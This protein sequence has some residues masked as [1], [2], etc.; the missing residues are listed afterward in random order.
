M[1]APLGAL[2]PSQTHVEHADPIP[3]VPNYFTRELEC[4]WVSISVHHSYRH[5]PPHSMQR[6][7]PPTGNCPWPETIMGAKRK[8]EPNG[9]AIL[10]R[11]GRKGGAAGWRWGRGLLWGGCDMWARLLKVTGAVKFRLQEG[12]GK[13]PAGSPNLSLDQDWISSRPQYG[14]D[15]HF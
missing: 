6:L 10:V 11:R 1:H 9:P 4:P 5:H 3:T 13:C 7:V 14:C 8:L 12:S 2:E 15:P